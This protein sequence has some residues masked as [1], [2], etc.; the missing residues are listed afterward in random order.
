MQSI[1]NSLQ[2]MFIKQTEHIHTCI[3]IQLLGQL[4]VMVMRPT[5]QLSPHGGRFSN[6]A[7]GLF[8]WIQRW[9]LQKIRSDYR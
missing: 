3:K 6:K 5:G 8:S 4:V 2:E 9:F 7:S 1:R